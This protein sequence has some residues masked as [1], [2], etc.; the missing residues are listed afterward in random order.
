MPDDSI[1]IK[2]IDE[3][4]SL[5][6]PLAE[7]IVENFEYVK[8]QKNDFLLIN[9]TICNKYMFIH[10]GFMRSYIVNENGKEIT[11]NFFSK[12][13]QAFEPAS[14]FNR[15]FSAENIQAV[16]E[17]CGWTVDF[18][19]MET[20]FHTNAGYREFGRRLLVKSMVDL[21]ER[22]YLLQTETAENKYMLLLKHHPDL[23]QNVPLKQIASYLGITDTSLSRIRNI[24]MKK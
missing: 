4:L 20:Y 2:F 16:T 17:C 15:S 10:K 23:L 3:Q 5:P 8:I 14:F 6:L 12:C 9:G 1:F 13:Q 19:K 22:M 7:E 11:T 18:Q 21:K 24:T